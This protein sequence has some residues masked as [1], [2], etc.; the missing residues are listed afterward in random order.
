[1][2]SLGL[3]MGLALVASVSQAAADTYLYTGNTLSD[4]SHIGASVDVA[5]T[6]CGAGTYLYSTGISSFLLT[7]YS[8]TNTPIY[9]ISTST[10]GSD[11]DGFG[12]Y[13]SLNGTGG[14]TSWSLF[15]QDKTGTD[16]YNGTLGGVVVGPLAFDA[17]YNRTNRGG[18]SYDAGVW[19][20]SAVPEPSTWAMMILGF[21]GL[22]FMAYRR[23]SSATLAA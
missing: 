7:D 22:G 17:A 1:M 12:E 4:G 18:N 11:T 16:Y 19:S 3:I 2:K 13:V 9:T 23:R 10:P 6:G 15:L 8:S 21:A 14:V 20:V 5:C